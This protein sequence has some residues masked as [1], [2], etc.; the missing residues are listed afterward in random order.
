MDGGQDLIGFD[1]I[2]GGRG[3]L[4]DAGVELACA[5]GEFGS[6][7]RSPSEGDRTTVELGV[8]VD[9]GGA[10]QDAP[11]G[12]FVTLADPDGNGLVLQATAA[13]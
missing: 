8:P 5:L 10:V 1:Q 3:E 2:S 11:W 6:G 9:G 4:D 13:G 7:G 12:R